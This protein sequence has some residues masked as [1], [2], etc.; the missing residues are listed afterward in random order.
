M[1]AAAQQAS[2]TPAAPASRHHSRPGS[3]RNH[4]RPSGNSSIPSASRQVGRAPTARP[5]QSPATATTGTGLQPCQA[6]AHASA[7]TEVKAMPAEIGN[8]HIIGRWASAKRWVPNPSART[9]SGATS[10]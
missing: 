1:M 5:R 9:P 10:T 2:G 4:A 6:T 8:S 7:A 3:R